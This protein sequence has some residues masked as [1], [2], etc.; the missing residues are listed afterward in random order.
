MATLITA[1]VRTSNPTTIKNIV[2]GYFVP[3]EKFLYLLPPLAGGQL[4]D[5][6][7]SRSMNF[8]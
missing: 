6:V 2:C 8:R 7:N 4:K 3:S 5:T 1:A